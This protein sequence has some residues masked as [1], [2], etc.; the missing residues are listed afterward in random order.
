MG[1]AVKTDAVPGKHTEGSVE[2]GVV[3]EGASGS[4][5]VIPGNT[6]MILNIWIQKQ[7]LILY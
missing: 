4:A 6:L 5:E 7:L 1:E 2:A 3:S